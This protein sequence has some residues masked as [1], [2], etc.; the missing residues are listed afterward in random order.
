MSNYYVH[1]NEDIFPDSRCFLPSRW[2]PKP[3]DPTN[4]PPT[5]PDGKKLLTRYMCSFSRGTRGCLGINLAWAE[6]YI[7]LATVMRKCE[8]ELYETSERDVR[9]ESEKFVAQARMGSKGVRV[10]VL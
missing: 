3:A 7:T 2:L 6:L 4:S 1:H 10:T 9:M 5:G 8:F